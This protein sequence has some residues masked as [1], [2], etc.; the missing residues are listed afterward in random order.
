MFAISSDERAFVDENEQDSLESVAERMERIRELVGAQRK[1]FA[2][3][4]PGILASR[5][6]LDDHSTGEN[7]ARVVA[8]AVSLIDNDDA[9]PVIVL[10]GSGYVGRRLVRELAAGKAE[11]HSVDTRDMAANWPAHLAGQSVTLVNVASRSAL[12]AYIDR[13]WTGMTILN[14][15][16]PEPDPDLLA[17]L[18]EKQIAVFH[19][20]GVQGSSYPPLPAAYAGAIPC[21]A[22]RPSERA[23]V[24]VRHLNPDV[25][26]GSPTLSQPAAPRRCEPL[27]VATQAFKEPE[28]ADA[29]S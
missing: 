3:V 6:V 26:P 22:A 13:L 20:V 23:N 24:V 16:Y 1:L 15:A 11:V 5:G 12:H 8:S 25:V 17:A 19:V 29:R 14:E 4:L 7:T 9:H 18:S 2:G 10:G 28:Y 21:C 27:D